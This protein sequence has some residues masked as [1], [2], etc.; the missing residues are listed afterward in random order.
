MVNQPRT[1]Q[2]AKKGKSYCQEA[3]APLSPAKALKRTIDIEVVV[4][5]VMKHILK[6]YFLYNRFSQIVRNRALKLHQNIHPK[7]LL[8]T[9][10]QVLYY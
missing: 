1:L 2:R 3:Q 8:S 4:V 6:I 7:F 10:Q 5:K 9:C